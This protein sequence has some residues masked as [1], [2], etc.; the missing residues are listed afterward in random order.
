MAIKTNVTILGS[1]TVVPSLTRS[2][3]S[4]LVEHGPWNLLFDLG[5]G[6][7]RCLL[8]VGATITWITH[9]FFSHLHPDHTGEFVSFLFVAKYLENR[10]RKTPLHAVGSRGFQSFYEKL[11]GA[12]GHWIVLEPGLLE[13]VELSGSGPDGLPGAIWWRPVR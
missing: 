4:F 10:G 6:I 8:E 12:Y 2:A 3:C 9:L 11:Q 5:S 13:I 1:G 7:M